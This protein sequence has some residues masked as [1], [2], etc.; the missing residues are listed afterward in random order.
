MITEE[1]LNN[2]LAQGF[3]KG[4]IIIKKLNGSIPQMMQLI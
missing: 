1:K 4:L 2:K 3:I